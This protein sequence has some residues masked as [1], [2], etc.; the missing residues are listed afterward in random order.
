[1][2][3]KVGPR[4]AINEIVDDYVM[5]IRKVSAWWSKLRPKLSPTLTSKKP[6]AA[7]KGKAKR[8]FVKR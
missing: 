6:L 1:M 7:E 3:E 8:L 2:A 5:N 4:R